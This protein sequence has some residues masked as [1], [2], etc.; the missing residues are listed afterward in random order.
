M[1]LIFSKWCN[2][3]YKVQLMNFHKAKCQVL[4]VEKNNRKYWHSMEA[5][6]VKSSLAGKNFRVLMETPL[7]VARQCW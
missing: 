3:W 1:E 7:A 2:Q 6:Q 5:E 4:H